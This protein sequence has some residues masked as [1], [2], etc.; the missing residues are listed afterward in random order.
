MTVFTSADRISW[1]IFFMKNFFPEVYAS[2]SSDFVSPLFPKNGEDVKVSVCFSSRPEKV[3]VRFDTEVGIVYKE[4]MYE[5]GFVNGA[6]RYSYIV[7]AHGDDFPFRYFFVFYVDGASYY[8]GKAGV[9]RHCPKTGD[10]FCLIPG[11][12]APSWV[13]S[14]V[15]YQVFPDRFNNGD[16]SIGAK[17]GE[18]VFDGC[19]VSNPAWTDIPKEWNE[20]HCVDFYNGDLKGI[21]DKVDYFKSLGVTTLYINPVFESQSTH[22]YDT[23]DFFHVDHKLGGDE[24][25]SKMV[26]TLHANGIKVILDISINHTGPEAVWLKK[27]QEDPSSDEAEFYYRK[28]DGSYECW[29][30]VPTLPQLNYNS[31]K[32]RDYMF[33]SENAVMQKFL[34]KPYDVDAWRLDVAPEVGRRG[35]D[36]LCQDVWREVR[37]S[38][39]A[40]KKD[41]YLVG[42]DWDDSTLYMAGDM[43]DATMNYYGSGRP[44]RSWLGQTDRFLLPAWGHECTHEKPWSGEETAEALKD[45]VRST[46]DQMAYFQMNLF[47]SHD[48]PRLH[49]DKVIMEDNAYLGCVLALYMLPGMPNIYYGDE[50]GLAGMTKSVE[51]SR[52]P[53][54]WR[55]ELWNTKLLDGHKAFGQIRNNDWFGF[56]S[57]D[58]EG[59]DEES[60]VLKRFAKG[61]A[62]VAFIN[63]G[64]AERVVST[65]AFLLPKGALEKVFGEGDCWVDNGQLFARLSSKKSLLLKIEG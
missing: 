54:E 52:Y 30:G 12:D 25:L 43:W 59:L 51:A 29:Q 36:Q 1:G 18:Y 27:G 5:D 50:I 34:K 58:A 39:K 38:L 20:A 4:Q 22:R 33:R 26:E 32:L 15:C 19:P 21:A 16:P 10:R 47:D 57:F 9:S 6:F 17:A 61:H 55:E 14:S 64:D 62:Y 65:S 42:E 24:A 49:N 7:K 41:L 46:L 8:Y 31:S 56:S 37:K 63:R 11:L 2:F 53:M 60:F 28:D 44:L 23:V 13:A 48:T 35:K 3:F 45:G 40:V